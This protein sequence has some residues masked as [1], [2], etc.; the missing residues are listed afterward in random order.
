LFLSVGWE[1]GKHP[2]KLAHAM[3]SS[4]TVFSAWDD[5]KLIGLCNALDDGVMTAYIHFLL[6]S[7]AY[8]GKGIGKKLLSLVT[9]KYKEYLRIILVADDKETG[10]YQNSGFESAKGTMAMFINRF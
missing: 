2:D 10:F 5:E 3:E 9:D 4:D 1:S 7:P 8:Q 6:V